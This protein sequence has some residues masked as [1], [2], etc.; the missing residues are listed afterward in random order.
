MRGPQSWSR[1]NWFWNPFCALSDGGRAV[2]MYFRLW[3][4]GWPGWEAPN[5]K[6]RDG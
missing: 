5:T 1:V 3:Y 2:C 4:L 6:V